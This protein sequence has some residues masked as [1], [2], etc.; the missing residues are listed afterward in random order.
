MI[1]ESHLFDQTTMTHLLDN[2]SV[3]Q[4]YRSSDFNLKRAPAT[5]ATSQ[6]RCDGQREV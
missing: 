2:D 4:D 5:L 6:D 3:V 1:P